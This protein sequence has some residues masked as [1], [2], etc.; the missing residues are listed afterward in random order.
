MA[1]IKVGNVGLAW[2]KRDE[3]SP[4]LALLTWLRGKSGRAFGDCGVEIGKVVANEGREA[5]G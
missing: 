5:E 1:S 2:R 4:T 3:Y